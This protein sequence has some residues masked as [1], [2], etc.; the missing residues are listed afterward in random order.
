MTGFND[1]STEVHWELSKYLAAVDLVSLERVS[2][3]LRSIY[4]PISWSK[5]YVSSYRGIFSN[6]DDQIYIND[7]SYRVVPFN[8]FVRL[9]LFK[10]IIL[11]KYIKKMYCSVDSIEHINTSH[12]FVRNKA[13]IRDYLYQLFPNL[14]EII[15]AS[16]INEIESK[17]VRINKPFILQHLV[18]LPSLQDISFYRCEYTPDQIPPEISNKIK[19][20]E[21]GFFYLANDRNFV[22]VSNPQ[23]PYL[24]NL[25]SLLL[26]SPFPEKYSNYRDI[27]KSI[28]KQAPKLKHLI[29]DFYP[30]GIEDNYGLDALLELPH[31]LETCE[32]YF[33]NDLTEVMDGSTP[34]P[35]KHVVLPQVTKVS[36][37]IPGSQLDFPDRGFLEFI[38]LPNVVE[39]NQVYAHYLFEYDK[40]ISFNKLTKINLQFHS[41][42]TLTAFLFVWKADMLMGIK[43]CW[44][45]FNLFN[46]PFNWDYRSIEKVTEVQLELLES[47]AAAANNWEVISRIKENQ[48]DAS[49]IKNALKVLEPCFPDKHKETDGSRSPYYQ[50]YVNVMDLAVYP[51][52]SLIPPEPPQQGMTTENIAEHDIAK[53]RYYYAAMELVY[54]RLLKMKNLKTAVVDSA[55]SIDFSPAFQQLIHTHENLKVLFISEYQNHGLPKFDNFISYISANH[56]YPQIYN[57]DYMKYTTEIQV[58][59]DNIFTSDCK[60]DIGNFLHRSNGRYDYEVNRYYIPIL[61]QLDAVNMPRDPMLRGSSV[62]VLENE[63]T[64]SYTTS[65]LPTNVACATRIM[66]RIDIEGMRKNYTSAFANGFEY[67]YNKNKTNWMNSIRV[68]EQLTEDEVTLKPEGQAAEWTL[69]DKERIQRNIC[70]QTAYKEQVPGFLVLHDPDEKI[71]GIP[72]DLFWNT[73]RPKMKNCEMLPFIN[74]ETLH[75]YGT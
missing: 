65:A 46:K 45:Q 14:V 60:E 39:L 67:Y 61:S 13:Q 54:D 44:F 50:S 52:S 9:E 31:D 16:P 12:D 40:T 68:I 57:K 49:E 24:P 35:A 33:D 5:V 11:T 28:K 10:T 19:R 43:H 18:S 25:E 62:D 75:I 38:H 59:E 56:E 42:D 3:N 41:F 63:G 64:Y 47:L 26:T 32:V 66:S 36:V 55:F 17:H 4:Q 74:Y 22:E 1:L 51:A 58:A 7:P 72:E 23:L 21:Y 8:I 2:Q 20:T 69:I 30:Y 6:P 34:R 53:L 70:L 73:V 29:L 27:I 37:G 15:I 71:E 48:M